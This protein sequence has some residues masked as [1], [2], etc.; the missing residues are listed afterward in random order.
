MAMK[1]SLDAATVE[2]AIKAYF[3][4]KFPQLVTSDETPVAVN[5]KVSQNKVTGVEVAV[6]EAG[7]DVSA[8][9]APKA[10]AKRG[11]RKAKEAAAE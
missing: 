8:T 6:G 10:G 2:S 3:R 4:T 7:E 11:P 9:F 5:V 1:L